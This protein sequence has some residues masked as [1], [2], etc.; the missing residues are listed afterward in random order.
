MNVGPLD[1]LFN[2]SSFG[3]KFGTD[4][5][6]AHTTFWANPSQ[7]W[8]YAWLFMAHWL[9]NGCSKA[10]L[11]TPCAVVLR[12]FFAVLRPLFG[13]IRHAHGLA[14]CTP[15]CAVRPSALVHPVHSALAHGGA[16]ACFRCVSLSRQVRPVTAQSDGS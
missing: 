2:G 10:G 12:A 8:T 13:D 1:G 11:G 14:P 4:Q 7:Q 15:C 16:V 6:R 3:S 5:T 9:T